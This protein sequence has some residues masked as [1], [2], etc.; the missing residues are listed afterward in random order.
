MNKVN[1]ITRYDIATQTWILGYYSAWRWITVASW[2]HA[3]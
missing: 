3:A 1:M 2:K